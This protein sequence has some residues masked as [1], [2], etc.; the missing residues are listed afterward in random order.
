M[1][2]RGKRLVKNAWPRITNRIAEHIYQLQRA[3]GHD[4]VRAEQTILLLQLFI[5]A[6]S[7]RS[8]LEVIPRPKKRRVR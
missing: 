1:R 4:V 6:A 2:S 5:F 7:C 3:S 8:I